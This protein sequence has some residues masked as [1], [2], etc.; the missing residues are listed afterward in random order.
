M[1]ALTSSLLGVGTLN[2]PKGRIVTP[3]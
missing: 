3:D 2:M 1:V